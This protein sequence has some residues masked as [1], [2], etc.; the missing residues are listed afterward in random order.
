MFNVTTRLATSIS[1][2]IISSIS[3]VVSNKYLSSHAFNPALT[4]E[5]PEVLLSG[6]RAAGW[7]CV[8]C[9]G[10]SLLI[11]AVG[12]RGLGVVGRAKAE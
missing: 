12:L 8:G 2:A 5:S 9:A 6:Y 7:M 10:V 4:S 11:S 3:S 1:L